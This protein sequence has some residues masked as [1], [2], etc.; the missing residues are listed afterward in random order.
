MEQGTHD[1]LMHLNGTYRGLVMAQEIQQSEDIDDTV[2]SDD[3]YES[4][5]RSRSPSHSIRSPSLVKSPS[6]S[7]TARV[8]RASERL[9]RSMCSVRSAEDALDADE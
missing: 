2:V 3:E 7:E 6:K 4:L 1:E 5:D 8:L 9:R